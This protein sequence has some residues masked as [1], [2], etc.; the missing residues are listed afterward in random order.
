MN[1]FI[2]PNFHNV[3]ASQARQ[4]ILQHP[5]GLKLHYVRQMLR[6]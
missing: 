3:N 5:S 4:N 1:N 2:E 6:G